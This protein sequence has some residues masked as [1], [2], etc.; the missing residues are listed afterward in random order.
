MDNREGT[1]PKYDRPTNRLKRRTDSRGHRD[2]TLSVN[3]GEQKFKSLFW[4]SLLD[5]LLFLLASC[6][7]Y[8]CIFHWLVCN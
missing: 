1:T 3:G 2:V 7:L 4:W 5:F 8:F 6:S